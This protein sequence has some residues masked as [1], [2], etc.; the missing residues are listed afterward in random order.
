MAE[1]KKKERRL[2]EELLFT[3]PCGKTVIQSKSLDLTILYR[4]LYEYIE[5]LYVLYDN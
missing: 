3:R 2:E 4:G 5:I 1:R